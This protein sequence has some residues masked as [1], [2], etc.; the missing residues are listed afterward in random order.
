MS[1]D[2]SRSS[3]NNRS[4]MP[5]RPEAGYDEYGSAYRRR[6]ARKDA[7][8]EDRHYRRRAVVTDSPARSSTD[9]SS[10]SAIDRWV[11]LDGGW[12][13]TLLGLLALCGSFALRLL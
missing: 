13:A 12:K 6:S 11:A 7:R 1:A 4:R 5:D 10:P 8:R 3:Y 9:D 2:R